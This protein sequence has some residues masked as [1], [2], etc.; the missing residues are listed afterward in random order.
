MNENVD[1]F[2]YSHV[3]FRCAV[4]N[5]VYKVLTNS[6]AP[7]SE[8]QTVL[9]IY[10]DWE[11]EGSLSGK[12]LMYNE[13]AGFNW[14]LK[15]WEIKDYVGMLHYR[16]FYT[17]MDEIPDIPAVFSFGF[18][19]ILNERFP[20][21]YNG[22]PKNNRE[23]YEIWHNVK[24]FDLMEQ[25]VKENYPQYAGGWD[26]MAKWNYIYPSSLFVM[27]KDLFKEYI[28]FALDVM[29]KFNKAR[30]CE[31]PEAWIKYVEGHQ[32]EY[33]RPQ[34]KYYTVQMQSRATGYLVE[35][36]LCAFLLAGDDPLVDHAA[37]FP[38]TLLPKNV[39]MPVAPQMQVSATTQNAVKPKLKK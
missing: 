22:V 31:T 19:I 11:G 9:P 6:H 4:S 3:P 36:C 25:I 17:F 14:I 30:G 1:I 35:R 33:I 7:D 38:W 8:F 32:D 21:Q 13:Y 24:D 15:N 26:K 18:K 37:E 39:W 29:D 10:R 16:R 34:H 20:L 5:P 28:T 2:V 12:N 23:F 27:P